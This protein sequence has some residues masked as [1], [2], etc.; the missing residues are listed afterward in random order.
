MGVTGRFRWTYCQRSAIAC[1][2]IIGDSKGDIVTPSC[3]ICMAGGR[4][5]SIV[6]IIKVPFV[7]NDCAIGICGTRAVKIAHEPGAA[8]VNGGS[9][10]NVRCCWDHNG[11]VIITG[12]PTVVGGGEMDRV[13]P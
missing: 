13:T 5:T 6:A 4:S 9:R 7:V 8:I 2:I 1:S 11:L 10:W 3:C 12:C